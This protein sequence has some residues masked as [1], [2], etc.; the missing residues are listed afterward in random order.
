MEEN[1]N[2]YKYYVGIKFRGG[3][4]SYY[5]SCPDDSLKVGDL[6]IVETSVGVDAGIVSS[7]VK[8]MNTY[9]SKL[10]LKPILRKANEEDIKDFDVANKVAITALEI[11]SKMVKKLGLAMNLIQAVYS[12]DLTKVMITYTSSEKRVDFRELLTKLAPLLHTRI[13]LHQIASRDKAKLIGGIGTCGLPLCCSTFLNSFDSISINMAKNQMLTINIPKLSGP[14]GKWLCCIGY[15]DELYTEAKKEFPAVGTKVTFD[16]ET[17]FVDSF[18]ILSKTIRLT[19]EAKDDFKT[20]SLEDVNAMLNH[21]Y[22]NNVKLEKAEEERT[23]VIPELVK[24]PVSNKQ[25]KHQY[26]SKDRQQGQ[27]ENKER[28]NNHQHRHNNNHKNHNYRNNKNEQ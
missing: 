24:E 20:F 10:S 27:K 17:Y 15:E 1:T 13:E 28:H 12:L 26:S 14:C 23:L 18:N 21:T 22:V 3:D 9:N 2:D 5:F 4:K 6:V 19:N 8:S 7:A 11:T 16:D 25:D